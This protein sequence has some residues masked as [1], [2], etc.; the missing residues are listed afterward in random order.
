M[1]LSCYHVTCAVES[2]LGLMDLCSCF[3]LSCHWE[4]FASLCQLPLEPRHSSCFVCCL[5]LNQL[6]TWG[7]RRIANE[8]SK[9]KLLSTPLLLFSRSVQTPQQ[10]WNEVAGRFHQ[11]GTEQIQDSISVYALD[12]IPWIWGLNIHLLC[13]GMWSVHAGMLNLGRSKAS[14]R[15]RERL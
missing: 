8:S 12:L 3:G 13:Q 15:E 5:F 7:V 14:K 1:Q 11:E 6:V 4:S 2:K 10:L 9:G